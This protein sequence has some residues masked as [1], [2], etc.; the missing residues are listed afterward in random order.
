MH[1]VPNLIKSILV[2]TEL[3]YRLTLYRSHIMF[4]PLPGLPTLLLNCSSGVEE[5]TESWEQLGH[6]YRS[7]YCL[8]I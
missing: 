5:Y 8:G 3:F 1:A 4:S 2:L 6:R 7:P